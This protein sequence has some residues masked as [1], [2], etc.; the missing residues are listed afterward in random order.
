MLCDPF[1][2]QYPHPHPPATESLR[3]L[4]P[5]PRVR[6]MMSDRMRGVGGGWGGSEGRGLR[7]RE[8]RADSGVT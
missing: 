3:D 7:L 8:A 2:K 5:R 6:A 4:F 1:S